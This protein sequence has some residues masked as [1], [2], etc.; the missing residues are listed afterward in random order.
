MKSH[1]TEYK[2]QRV[3]IADFSE[4]GFDSASLKKECD[5]I[6]A[7]LSKE[8][9]KSVRSISLVT[10]TIGTTAMLGGFKALVPITTKYVSKRCAVGLTG[11]RKAF[12][13]TINKFTADTKM[14]SFD[15]L[16]EALE[17]ITKD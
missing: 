11:L 9:P 5:E 10:G 4:L 1:W 12:I 14:Y 15:T 3:F 7:E 13:D 2:G 17:W 6:I 8:P 16:E